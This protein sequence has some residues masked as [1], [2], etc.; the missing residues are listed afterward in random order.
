MRSLFL[1]KMS[2]NC[3]TLLFRI[4]HEIITFSINRE[5]SVMSQ[6]TNRDVLGGC[7]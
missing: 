4:G 2:G 1:F 3:N 7:S 6:G 5:V